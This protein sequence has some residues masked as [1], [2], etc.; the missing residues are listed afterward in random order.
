MLEYYSYLIEEG[1]MRVKMLLKCGVVIGLMVFFWGCSVTLPNI[2]PF[3]EQTRRMVSAVDKG[4]THA[5]TLLSMVE[6]PDESIE[7]ELTEEQ[8]ESLAKAEELWSSA[9]SGGDALKKLGKNWKLMKKVLKALVRYS[10]ELAALAD[11]GS[12]GEEAAHG[13]ADA[14]NGILE[15]MSNGALNIPAKLVTA[16]KEINKTLARI[17]ARKAL[18]EAVE[19]AQP[20][21]NTIVTIIAANLDELAII[22]EMAGRVLGIRHHNTNQRMSNYYEALIESQ[23]T[24]FEILTTIIRI[25]RESNWS[26]TES[27]RKFLLKLDPKFDKDVDGKPTLKHIELREKYWLKNLQQIKGE[28]KYLNPRY[29][30][31]KTREEELNILT[32][33]GSLILRKGKSAIQEYGNAH[34]KLK[35]T[36]GKKQRMSFLEFAAVVQEV[37]DAYKEVNNGKD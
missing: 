10:D 5:E 36:L 32:F 34:M 16:F 11:A 19:E 33:T 35:K 18:K 28:I 17:R 2:R 20:V 23:Q 37:V 8:K 31:F 27:D 30:S 9:D 21:I 14:L 3:A 22:N 7:E 25:K 6:E 15:T 13:V 4:Y 24:I 1:N 29:Q 26:D 12:K